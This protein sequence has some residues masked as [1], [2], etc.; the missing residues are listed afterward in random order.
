MV[1]VTTYC[2]YPEG[3]KDKPKVG[4]F[5]TVDIEKVVE[6]QPDL[7]LAT[8]V[9]EAELIPELERLGLTVL[10]L[11]PKT[12]DEVLEAITLVGKCTGKEDVASQLVTDMRNRVTAIT[13]KTANL[14]EAQ[15]PRVFYAVRHDPLWTV[16]ADHRIHELIVLA[17]GINIAQDLSGSTTISMEAV[18][19]ANPQVIIANLGPAH[20]GPALGVFLR[21][22]E[23]LGDVDARINNRIYEIDTGLIGR[24]GP[25]IVDALELLAKMIHPEIFGTIG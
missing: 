21:T 11:Y 4:G 12:L 6:I 15:R 3:A 16:G 9:H 20:S 8:R 7:I 13:D 23:R 10:N 18:I 25:R 5:T 1:G 19:Q 17:G 22:E 2:D 24:A 14:T